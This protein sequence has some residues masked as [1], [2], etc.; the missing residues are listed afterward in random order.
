MASEDGPW[1]NDTVRYAPTANRL[2]ARLELQQPNGLR[3]VQTYGDDS[4]NRL[5]TLSLR[6]V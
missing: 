6:L 3:W 2:R 4:G 1:A 5:T